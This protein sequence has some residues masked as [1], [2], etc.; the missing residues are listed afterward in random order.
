MY[1]PR[2]EPTASGYDVWE[3]VHVLGSWFPTPGFL[4]ADIV[5]EVETYTIVVL[6]TILCLY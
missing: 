6:K 1:C 5:G 2:L 4:N 3:N